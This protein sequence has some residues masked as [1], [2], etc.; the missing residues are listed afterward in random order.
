MVAPVH[1]IRK[2]VNLLREEIA[3]ISRLNQEY[4][5]IIHT[6][7]ARQTHRERRDRL[8]RILIELK[9]LSARTIP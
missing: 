4:S 2:R 6:Q 1:S 7:A 3:E 5:H 8:E 9:S